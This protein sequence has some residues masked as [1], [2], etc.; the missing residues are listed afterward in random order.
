M[1]SV[2][3]QDR[4][5]K[6]SLLC[7]RDFP[8]FWRNRCSSPCS[9]ELGY[10]NVSTASWIH[11]QNL[12]RNLSIATCHVSS[13]LPRILTSGICPWGL[14]VNILQEF[15]LSPRVLFCISHMSHPPWLMPV[16]VCSYKHK[17]S[18]ANSA[19]FYCLPLISLC[20]P[21]SNAVCLCREICW[22]FRDC[23]YFCLSTWNSTSNLNYIY[24][25]SPYR[26]VNTLRLCYKN[27]SVN[28]V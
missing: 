15:L 18:A 12:T 1:I 4:L 10:V 21:F 11:P 8:C 6:V 3:A 17:L 28:V 23:L 7:S 19:V 26:A 20:H 2:I 16:A 24:R 9:E 27:Q 13:H 5:W 22:Y 25:P 14:S